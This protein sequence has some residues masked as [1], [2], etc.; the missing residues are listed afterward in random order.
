MNDQLQLSDIWP[1]VVTC[2]INIPW[3]TNK[4]AEG[5]FESDAKGRA[6][7][8]Y[9][10]FQPYYPGASLNRLNWK[11]LAR[12]PRRPMLTEF[13]EEKRLTICV[14]T[15]VSEDMQFGAQKYNKQELAAWLTGS[16]L[17]SAGLTQEYG[18][19]VAFS[20]ERIEHMAPNSST[21]FA[22]D[23]A[24][25]ATEQTLTLSGSN[26]KAGDGPSQAL[27]YL[28]AERSLVVLVSDFH[29]L[30]GQDKQAQLNKEA[31]A[32][33]ASRHEVICLVVQD[34]DE[35]EL[36]ALKL[37]GLNLPG[38]LTVG[39]EQGLGPSTVY[40]GKRNQSDHRLRVARHYLALCSFFCANNCKYATFRTEESEESRR[41]RL[42]KVLAGDRRQL[43]LDGDLG[44]LYGEESG[45]DALNS[46]SSLEQRSQS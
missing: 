19:F 3:R 13:E 20:P 4:Q 34:V 41:E 29:W 43:C 12:D 8:V 1:H 9:C 40:T 10:D 31:L 16:L 33:A 27:S 44:N 35:R 6:G 28:P 14:L 22:A 24:L 18:R 30:A 45:S 42:A 46:S 36:P 39:Q 21:S 38:F 5:Q 2:P 26:A 37:F 32:L 23:L 15:D 17:R 11:L 7:S 25:P